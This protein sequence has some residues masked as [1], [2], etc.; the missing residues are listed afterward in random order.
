MKKAKP[1]TLSDTIEGVTFN[2]VNDKRFCL[3]S[4][5]QPLLRSKELGRR[6]SVWQSLPNG[7]SSK[8]KSSFERALTC[9]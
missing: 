2:S 4:H 5:Q 9:P 3:S 8:L 7:N 1:N 6:K